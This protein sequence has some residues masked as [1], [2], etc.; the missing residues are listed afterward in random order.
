MLG[1]YLLLED[2][3]WE[4]CWKIDNSRKEKKA[5]WYCIKVT[6]KVVWSRPAFC[7][8]MDCTVHGILQAKMLEWVAFPLLQG[9]FPTQALSPGLQILISWATREG[10]DI[11]YIASNTW[12]LRIAT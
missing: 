1:F 3:Y 11:A 4:K 5:V 6:V 2:S 10:H 9:I 7:N 12:I 8:P